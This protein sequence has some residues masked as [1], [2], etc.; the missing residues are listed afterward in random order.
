MAALSDSKYMRISRFEVIDV[1]LFLKG[2]SS[3]LGSIRCT[4]LGCKAQVGDL[5]TIS[6]LVIMIRVEKNAM[7]M[8]RINI[9]ETEEIADFLLS[10]R[11]GD[12]LDMNNVASRHDCSFD[13]W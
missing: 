4:R 2:Y 1:R 5:S 12:A 13:W 3:G 8:I 7:T 11:R 9:P 10:S 6:S